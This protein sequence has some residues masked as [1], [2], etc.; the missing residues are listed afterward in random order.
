MNGLLR[1]DHRLTWPEIVIAAYF[2]HKN[3]PQ[4]P[5]WQPALSSLPKD[6][7]EEIEELLKECAVSLTAMMALKSMLIGPAVAFLCL[8]IA[9]TSGLNTIMRSLAGQ[10]RFEPLNQAI[11]T[12]SAEFAHS[13]SAAAT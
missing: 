2:T 6:V 5:P 8:I 12:T 11:Q 13:E 3:K 10:K 9:C 7:R 1:F 4:M